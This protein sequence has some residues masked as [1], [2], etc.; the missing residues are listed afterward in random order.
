MGIGMANTTLK[1]TLRHYLRTHLITILLTGFFAI[2]R[3]SNLLAVN[4]EQ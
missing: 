4:L 1:D 3:S 2:N